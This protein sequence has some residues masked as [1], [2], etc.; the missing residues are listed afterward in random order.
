MSRVTRNQEAGPY[1]TNDDFRRIFSADVDRY[2][3]LAFILTADPERAEQAFV[4]AVEDCVKS[5]QVFKEWAH[6]WAKRMVIQRA[7]R[8]VHRPAHADLP[9]AF[10]FSDQEEKREPK[11]SKDHFDLS[12]VLSL[13]SFERFVFVVT[14]LER[15]SDHECAQLLDCLAIEVR[16]ARAK[17]FEQLAHSKRAK[18]STV[19]HRNPDRFEEDLALSAGDQAVLQ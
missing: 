6:S 2:Y 11:D 14:V 3:Q 15:Y 18:E 10:I 12:S 17:A 13:E 5:N 16:Q 19:L 8:L 9:S 4:A 7:S 1:A